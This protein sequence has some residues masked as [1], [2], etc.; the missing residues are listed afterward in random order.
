MVAIDDIGAVVITPDGQ[1]LNHYKPPVQIIDELAPTENEVVTYMQAV[2]ASTFVIR[3]ALGSGFRFRGFNTVAFQVSV[4]EK[5]AVHLY[6]PKATYASANGT[7]TKEIA[8]YTSRDSKGQRTEQAFT[9]SGRTFFNASATAKSQTS[10]YVKACTITIKALAGDLDGQR[11]FHK[12]ANRE[13][14]AMFSF[15][16]RT[17]K[18]IKDLHLTRLHQQRSTVGAQQK[19]TMA[20]DSAMQRDPDKLDANLAQKKASRNGRSQTATAPAAIHDT[21]KAHKSD[22]VLVLQK[23]SVAGGKAIRNRGNPGTT[24]INELSTNR[25]KQM[26]PD[27][28]QVDVATPPR[29][30]SQ[31]EQQPEGYILIEDTPEPEHGVNAEPSNKVKLE[32]IPSHRRFDHLDPVEQQVARRQEMIEKIDRMRREVT[33]MQEWPMEKM[34]RNFEKRAQL[35]S[36]KRIAEAYFQTEDALKTVKQEPARTRRYPGVNLIDLTGDDSDDN[37]DIM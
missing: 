2:P 17:E 9:F 8:K 3:V 5:A 34:Q 15:H 27:F 37:D 11:V 1:A 36:T 20:E 18:V 6:V 33:P 25:A 14:L 24:A 22:V 32:K 30:D 7:W 10:P 19:A 16:A 4:G 29:Q 21:R 31:L 26:D 28:I 23:Y 35:L 12:S 13:P